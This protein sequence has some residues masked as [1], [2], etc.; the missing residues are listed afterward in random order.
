MFSNKGM[1]FETNTQAPDLYDLE[2]LQAK[3]YQ[4]F[5]TF[6][7]KKNDGRI[8]KET[9]AHY[10]KMC[11]ETQERIEKVEKAIHNK[12]YGNLTKV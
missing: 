9:K 5:N 12:M 6:M 1:K 3:L 4:S 2:R 7:N 8:S 10:Q 11:T